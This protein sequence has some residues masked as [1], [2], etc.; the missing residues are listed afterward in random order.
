MVDHGL[1]PQKDPSTVSMM[2]SGLNSVWKIQELCSD[3]PRAATSSWSYDFA[4]YYL[5]QT[6]PRPW[7]ED[8]S[9]PVIPVYR[10][11]LPDIDVWLQ[12]GAQYHLLQCSGRMQGHNFNIC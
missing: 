6:V 7:S 11:K 10:G 12:A 5:V 3:V 4:E 2:H 9:N 1:A 8:S